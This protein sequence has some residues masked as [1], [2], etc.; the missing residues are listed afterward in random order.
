VNNQFQPIAK[1]LAQSE[2][3]ANEDL[4]L[5]LIEIWSIVIWLL[6][7]PNLTPKTKN[8]ALKLFFLTIHYSPTTIHCL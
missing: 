8:L 3:Y 2:P 7:I 5:S 1:K 4:A 6:V